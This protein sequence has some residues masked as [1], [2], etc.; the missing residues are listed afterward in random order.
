MSIDL[1]K[2]I[3]ARQRRAEKFGY[4]ISTADVYVRTLAERA[5]LDACYRSASTR[6]T[7][8][9]DVLQ[10]AARTLVYSNPEMV[11]EEA[12]A[13]AADFKRL[14]GDKIELPKNALMVFRHKL[15][16]SREDRD[17]DIL[18]SDGMEVDPKML[19]LWQHVHTMPIGKYLV[20]TG[21]DNKSLTVVSTIVD[22]NETSHD[23]AVMIDN[24]MGR[25]SHGFR[26]IDHE[27]RKDHRGKEVGGFEIFKAEIMEESLV[28]VPAN[29]DAGTEEVLLSLV[30]GGKLTSPMMKAVGQS[31]REHRPVS[32]G[33]VT[34]K[35]REKLGD[36]QR[37]LACGSL[38]DLK[39]AVDAG[40]IGTNEEN[41]DEDES[42]VGKGTGE[43]REEK[44]GAGTSKEADVD[45][46]KAEDKDEAG[47]D[48]VVCP[49]CGSK[50]IK[51]GKCQDCGAVMPEGSV[52][53]SDKEGKEAEVEGTKAEDKPDVATSAGRQEMMREEMGKK[54]K[55]PKCGYTAPMVYWSPGAKQYVCPKCKTDMADQF[56]KEW[57]VKLGKDTEPEGTK[58]GRVLSSA[59]E[60]MLREAVDD[61]REA[62][63]MEMPR[64]AKSLIKT[65]H[66]QI[67]SVLGSLGEAKQEQELTA[68]QAA[69]EFLV[70]A[71]PD[72][73]KRLQE[74]IEAKTTESV[75]KQ[76]TKQYMRLIKSR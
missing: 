27:K 56:P 14:A 62:H 53:G 6:Q 20:T 32:V 37:E 72:E 73:M 60:K 43:G 74:A 34:I 28:S 1:L 2:A 35:Y 61:L 67:K 52:G 31:I 11:L 15:T 3:K 45:G 17:K 13:Q 18:H 57:K 33:G 25:F 55:C 65:A 68:K 7:S 9:D 64:P 23:A 69:V 10:K 21:Q 38:Q 50:N 39:A 5:G 42:G 12:T 48:E 47:D 44:D 19:L 4:G 51:D 76:R 58:Q 59:N 54:V 75:R 26:S 8:F 40:L 36:Y 63:G 49:K 66:D 70:K 24:D 71:T 16:S 41:D 29:I 46:T 22:M 30:E